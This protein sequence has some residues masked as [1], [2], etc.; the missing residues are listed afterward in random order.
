MGSNRRAHLAV[1]A[2]ALT[3]LKEFRAEIDKAARGLVQRETAPRAEGPAGLREL[4]RLDYSGPTQRRSAPFPIVDRLNATL[5]PSGAWSVAV[6]VK[7]PH[8]DDPW[9]L[10][11]VAKF[12]VRSGGRPV[13]DW[14]SLA[15]TD[16]CRLE[17]GNLAVDAGV[18]RA[19]F[20]G[21]TDPATHPV[22]GALARLVIEVQKARGGVA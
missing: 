17:R 5:E 11:P 13:V 16:N 9:L 22:R 8:A 21:V 18:R 14:A 15:A 1:R 6:T 3:R 19:V 2:G 10:T 7:L 4:L 20:H 12:D